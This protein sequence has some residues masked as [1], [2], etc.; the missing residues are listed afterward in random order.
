MPC[1]WRRF[2]NRRRLF[3]HFWACRTVARL[4]QGSVV[5]PAG[6]AW[7]ASAASVAEA[8]RHRILRRAAQ[9]QQSL[10]CYA[11]AEKVRKAVVTNGCRR[12]PLLV[13]LRGAEGC[14]QHISKI[15]ELTYCWCVTLFV[16]NLV[17]Y[18]KKLNDFSRSQIN[19]EKPKLD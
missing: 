15:I 7:L 14:W 17:N 13:E 16:P 19:L 18:L 5:T 3:R 12:F 8:S 4:L 11:V 10:L 6:D 1:C 2:Q 9:Q